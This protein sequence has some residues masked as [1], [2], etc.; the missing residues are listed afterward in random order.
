MK[1]KK[2]LKGIVTVKLDNMFADAEFGFDVF[3]IMKDGEPAIK[4]FLFYEGKTGKEN[5]FKS[6]IQDS[7]VESIRERFLTNEAE[8]AMAENIADNQNK[9]YIIEQSDAY[10]PFE[11]LNTPEEVMGSFHIEKTDNADAVL[12][13]FRREEDVIW[14]YQ[15][16][17]PTT[18]PNKKKQH[19]LARILSTEYDDQFIE[20][21]DQLFTITQKVNL[22]IIGDK[23][24]TKDIALMQ[25]HFGFESFIRSAARDA[26]AKVSSIQLVANVEK[27][28]DYIER[29]QKKYS[30][31]MMRIKNYRVV[32]KTADELIESITNLPRWRGVF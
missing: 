7:I 6:K 20:M 3:I 2:T 28:T 15:S 22:L 18:I 26:V 14:A 5:D 25:R 10:R 29:N 17:V 19:F 8:Y 32:D 1:L 27:L 13:R 21:P 24:V 30:K 11:V 23:I 4:R 9:F 12:F 16:I 31:K